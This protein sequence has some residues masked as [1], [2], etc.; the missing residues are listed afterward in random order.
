MSIFFEEP[1][2]PPTPNKQRSQPTLASPFGIASATNTKHEGILKYQVATNG[3]YTTR[4][5]KKGVAYQPN[6]A[7]IPQIHATVNLYHSTARPEHKNKVWCST[8]NINR[9]T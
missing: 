1:K 2:Y 8:Q 5:K 4:T 6:I 7:G 3:K 9:L